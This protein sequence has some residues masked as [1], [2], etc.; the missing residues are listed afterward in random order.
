MRCM[1][2]HILL[3][4]VGLLCIAGVT[5]APAAQ[6]GEPRSSIFEASDVGM[7]SA[8]GNYSYQDRN[9][10]GQRMLESQSAYAVLSVDP[11]INWLTVS[12]GAGST[13]V[14][15]GPH[16]HYEEWGSM[17]SAEVQLGLWEYKIKDPDF[18]LSRVRVLGSGSYWNHS[19]EISDQDVDW[20]EWRASLVFSAEFFTE[21]LGSDREV[22]P[23]AAVYSIGPVYSSIERDTCAC[24]PGRAAPLHDVDRQS[25]WGLQVGIDVYISHNL[26]LGWEARTFDG[27]HDRSHDLHLA[28]HF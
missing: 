27:F 8:S 15:P 14:K 10:G 11:F 1:K 20:D 18:M 6:P 3:T 7:F 5:V 28:F 13:Q 12:L 2:T 24:V 23:Y 16:E 22:Y 4:V 19:A 21:N 26:S 9:I 17:W 25:N